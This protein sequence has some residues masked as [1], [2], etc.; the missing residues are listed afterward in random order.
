MKDE[1]DTLTKQ[2]GELKTVCE[3]LRVRNEMLEYH[4]QRA[5]RKARDLQR[6]PRVE[7]RQRAAAVGELVG[8]LDGP[9]GA[10]LL[11][12]RVRRVLEEAH[13]PTVGKEPDGMR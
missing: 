4:L 10:A 6:E 1:F 8:D 2:I 5:E 12:V 7:A 9:G 3:E 11:D 13:A